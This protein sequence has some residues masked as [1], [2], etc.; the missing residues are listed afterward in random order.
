MPPAGIETAIPAIERMQN[1]ALDLTA[2]WISTNDICEIES[3]RSVLQY[4]PCMERY[5]QCNC[6]AGRASHWDLIVGSVKGST[7]SHFYEYP[8]GIS[9]ATL[10]LWAA[11]SEKVICSGT[12]HDCSHSKFRLSRPSCYRARHATAAGETWPLL[13]LVLSCMLCNTSIEV[14]TT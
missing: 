11:E 6:M 4:A 13:F 2:T 1:Y 14:N 12:Q 8:V 3:R 9:V 5:T 10:P 7:Q